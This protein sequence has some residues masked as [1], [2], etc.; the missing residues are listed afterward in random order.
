MKVKGKGNRGVVYHVCVVGVF[1]PDDGKTRKM[2]YGG[3]S[4]SSVS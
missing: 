4:Y 1:D 2:T 3:E